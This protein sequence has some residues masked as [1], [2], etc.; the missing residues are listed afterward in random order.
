MRHIYDKL[1]YLANRVIER[2]NST[3][4]ERYTRIDV[5][6][7]RVELF[8]VINTSIIYRI[9]WYANKSRISG[10]VMIVFSFVITV[11]RR[12]R[13]HH[14]HHCYRYLDASGRILCAVC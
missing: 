1:L 2:A 10:K 8:G 5:V 4:I 14:R 13:H 12:R 6:C 9:W 11:D 3:F 7:K